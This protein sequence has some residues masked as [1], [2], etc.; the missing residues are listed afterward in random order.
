MPLT[1]VLLALSICA[2]WLPSIRVG[3][4]IDAPPWLVLLFGAIASGLAQGYLTFLA[5]L[6][7]AL[8]G[9][10]ARLATQPVSM[11][12]QRAIGVST[13]CVLALVIALHLL[14]GFHNPLL[15]ADARFSVD[16]APYTQYA[17]F[18][19]AVGGLL[20]LAFLCRRTRTPAEF[21]QLLRNAAIPVLMTTTIVIGTAVA[22]RYVAADFKL[23]AYTPVFL[24]TNLLFSCVAEEAF[25]RGVIQERL[26]TALDVGRIGGGLVILIS[27]LLFGLA[28]YAG[29]MT[30]VAISS[31]LGCGC[32]YCY[33][34]TRRVEA[35]I[36]AHF[37]LN[38]VHFIGFTYPR[39][40]IL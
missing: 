34:I 28:H 37:A 19:K 32:A 40:S 6:W 14:P 11:R 38:G 36:L 4:K 29:G 2:V 16:A 3:A 18:D 25:F 23:P 31:V 9:V 17:N 39:L 24:I 8:L 5:V 33:A 21:R 30:Y 7:I 10:A 12:W 15:I 27:G 26:A 22:L 20:L 35:P 1:F 13:A